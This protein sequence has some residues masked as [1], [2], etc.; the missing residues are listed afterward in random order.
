MSLFRKLIK[1]FRINKVLASFLMAA[2]AACMYFAFKGL[3]RLVRPNA[4]NIA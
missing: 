2:F 1:L 3:V 4:G